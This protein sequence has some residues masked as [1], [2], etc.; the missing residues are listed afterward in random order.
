MFISFV[1]Y[2]TLLLS[3]SSLLVNP[4]AHAGT[5]DVANRLFSRLASYKLSSTDPRRSQME[6]LITQGNLIAA[7]RIAS[8]DDSF[9]NN[10]VKQF[11]SPMSNRE[12]NARVALTDFSAMFIGVA[13]DNRD[14]RELLYGDF[15]YV[16]NSNDPGYQTACTTADCI[17]SPANGSPLPHFSAIQNINL[18]RY[19]TRITPQRSDVPSAAGVLTSYAWAASFFSAGT[20]RRAT[21]YA[22]QE[23]LCTSIQELSDTTVIDNRVRQDVDRAPGGD[24]TV[25]QTSCRGCHGGMDGLS[26]AWAHFDNTTMLE[27]V[28]I[29]AKFLQNSTVFPTGYVTT[30]DSWVNYFTKNQNAALGWRGPLTGNGPASLG[31]MLSN[32]EA[33]SKCMAKRAFRKMC[34]R[35][36]SGQESSQIQTLANKFEASTY[37]LRLLLEEAAILPACLGN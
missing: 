2:S 20:N 17:Y 5:S 29:R 11:A 9:Y 32:S 28:S 14:A 33:F 30:D 36:P 27:S 4:T 18:R 22:L 34:S 7:A 26:G 25:Y 35:D 12:E 21:A 31:K 16:G 24:P 10:T 13:R 6:S 1:K 3:L 8:D 23:F 37:N 19:L 15:L